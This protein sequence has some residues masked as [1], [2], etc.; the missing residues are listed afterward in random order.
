MFKNLTKDIVDIEKKKKG[1]IQVYRAETA[2]SE[3]EKYTG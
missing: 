1:L 3:T 2:M